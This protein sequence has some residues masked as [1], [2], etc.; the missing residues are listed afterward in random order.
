[1]S[2]DANSVS[3]PAPANKQL[4]MGAV[5]ATFLLASLGQTIITTS[6]PIIVADLGGIEYI[7]WAVTAYLLAATVAAPMFGKLGDM[8]GRKLLLQ[9]GIGIFLCASVLAALSV[10]MTMMVV[11]RFLQGLG[12]GGLIVTAMASIGDVLSPRERGK[13]QGFIGAAFGLS[14]II[15][16]LLGGLIVEALSWRWLFFVNIPVGV[17]AFAVISIAF[18]SRTKG[19]SRQIDYL[20]AALLTTTLASLVIYTSIGGTILPWFSAQAL[21]LP[22]IA[23]VALVGF[24]FAEQ[25]SEEPILPLF[26]FRNNAFL[27]SNSVGF[28]VGTVMF[29]VITFLPSYMLIVRGF[30][31]T[32][33]GLALVPMMAGMI[34]SSTWAGHYISRTG[35]YKILPIG[36]TVLLAVGMLLFVTLDVNTPIPLVAI[37]MLLVGLGMGPVQSVGIT[38]IQNSVPRSELGVGTAS[39]QMFRQ[40]GGSLGVSGLGA[41]FANRL[42]IET[43]TVGHPEGTAAFAVEA[44]ARLPEVEKLELLH[45]YTSALHPIFWVAAVAAVIASVLS[46]L[47]VEEPLAETPA[48]AQPEPSAAE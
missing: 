35:R 6:L 18:E 12:G 36:S 29:G 42:A 37:Y 25:K 13:A 41:L 32:V 30:S 17:L 46:W 34:G 39:V 5:L 45:A 16:P 31:P 26:L 20:G 48:R 14:T 7:S 44:L 23:L 38:A 22:A 33:A 27:V 2:S 3:T 1:M 43:A 8:Y 10:N 47:L 15:G 40:I 4:V 21:A 11:C 9:I 24:V 28:V 19:A